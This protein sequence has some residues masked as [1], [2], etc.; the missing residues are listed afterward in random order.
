MDI[1]RLSFTGFFDKCSLIL[2]GLDFARP[3]LPGRWLLQLE[4]VLDIHEPKLYGNPYYY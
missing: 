3:R 1:F 2:V 4:K